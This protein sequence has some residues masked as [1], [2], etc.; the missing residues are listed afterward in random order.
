[1]LQ[2]TDASGCNTTRDDDCAAGPALAARRV[3]FGNVGEDDLERSP[4][5]PCHFPLLHLPAG[6][7][8]DSLAAPHRMADLGEI[9]IKQFRGFKKA[10]DRPDPVLG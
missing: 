4:G 6:S 7:L 9:P 3:E 1:M 10:F 5:H 8:R 2:P